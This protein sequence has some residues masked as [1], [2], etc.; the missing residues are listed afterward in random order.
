MVVMIV[1]RDKYL[2]ELISKKDNG[3]VK[4][5]TGLRR[6]G[7]S[8]LLFNLFY[9]HLLESGVL[10]E[11]IITLSLEEIENSHLWNVD[12]FHNYL[13]SK[14][15]D[16]RKYYILIDEIQFVKPK[17][18]NNN[19]I[20]FHH[21]LLSLMKKADIYV[22]GSNSKMLSSDI[23]TEFRGRANQIHLQPLTFKEYYSINSN[24]DINDIFNE[25]CFYGGLPQVALS[26]SIDSKINYLNDIF[27]LVYKK[28]IIDR[29]N[30]RNEKIILD[31]LLDILSSNVGSL[32]NPKRLS[33]TYNSI[34]K[35]KTNN[36]TVKR[37]IDY[38]I[39]SFIINNVNRYDIKGNKIFD[40]P[41]KYYFSDVGI[42][43]SRMNFKYIDLNHI[44]ENVIYNELIYRG[45][46]VNVGVIES[47]EKDDD[48]KTI[49]KK[50]EIDF[51]A[52]KN[53]ETI[54]IQFADSVKTNEK[55]NQEIRGFNKISDSYQKILLTNDGNSISWKNEKGL[56]IKDVKKFLLDN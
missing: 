49:R 44:I 1:K 8:F 9:N 32:T 45:Y 18:E 20:T 37:Y 30:L 23:I 17:N 51:V 7:K 21:S 50:Y 10:P 6:C 52:N 41:T 47:F 46:V 13:K 39:D 40:S 22:T 34:N 5:V 29:Y 31:P 35:D 48:S 16:K 4:V 26:D 27:N 54:Y 11:Q 36:K 38:F 42:R 24:H 25:Y 19:L 28:D 33:D 43:N 55:L 14:I 56:I 12:S 2:E 15:D 53:N 3:M